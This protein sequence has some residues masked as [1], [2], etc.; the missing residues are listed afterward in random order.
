MTPEPPLSRTQLFRRVIVISTNFAR[1]LAYFRAAQRDGAFVTPQT[2]FWRT[3]TGNFADIATLEWC[4]L[5][6]DPRGRPSGQHSWEFVVDDPDVFW[7]YILAATNLSEGEIEQARLELR[8]YRDRF[9]AHLDDDR[10][11]HIP[12]FDIPAELVWYYCEFV[13]DAGAREGLAIQRDS[14][15]EFFKDHRAAALQ[16]YAG[17]ER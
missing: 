3:A 2:D 9:V 12:S 8:R 15:R 16:L 13:Q 1:N 4:K 17:L 14:I 10:I 5:F 7:A 11:M 6:G